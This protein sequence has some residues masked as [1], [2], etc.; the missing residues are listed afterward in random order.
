MS[1]ILI[2][3]IA[4]DLCLLGHLT[5]YSIYIVGRL[6]IYKHAISDCAQVRFL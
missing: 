2:I 4:C 3:K 5:F 1:F 6:K